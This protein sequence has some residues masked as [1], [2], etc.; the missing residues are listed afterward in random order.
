MGPGRG[1]TVLLGHLFCVYSWGPAVPGCGSGSLAV[2][3]SV[4][5]SVQKPG[6]HWGEIFH[7]TK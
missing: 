6:P 1:S 5:G 2:V 7:F 3:D 4:L